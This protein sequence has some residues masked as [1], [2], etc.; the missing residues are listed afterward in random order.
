M[1]LRWIPQPMT[2]SGCDGSDNFRPSLVSGA[3]GLRIPTTGI[4]RE[5]VTTIYNSIVTPELFS[6]AQAPVDH[7]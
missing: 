5:C 1:L 4:S 7:P 6:K 2:M 3:H